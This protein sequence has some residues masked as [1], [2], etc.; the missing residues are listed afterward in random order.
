MKIL[1]GIVK[2]SALVF[3]G[4]IMLLTVGAYL[5]LP[6]PLKPLVVQSGSMEPAIRT[7]SLV[8]VTKIPANAIGVDYVENDIITFRSGQELVSHRIVNVFHRVD[9]KYFQVKGDANNT[10]DSGLVS[11]RD[12]VGKVNFTIPYVGRFVNF[13][14]QPLGFILLVTIP[15]LFVI[16]SEALVIVE[17]I[18]KKGSSKASKFDFIK[19][20]AMFFMTAVFLTGTHSFFSSVASSTNNT[21]TAA[22]FFV[23]RVVINE[24]NWAG[25]SAS[26]DDEWIELF[27]TT[28]QTIDISGWKLTKKSGTEVT[29][30]TIPTS[31]SIGPGGF[32]LISNFNIGNPLTVLNV[33][34][35]LVDTSVALSNATLQI[36]LYDN[37]SNVIDTAWD[38]SPPTKGSNTPPKASMER[39]STILD[40]SLHTSWHTA[41]TSENLILGATEHATPK[42]VNGP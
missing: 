33:T 16:I 22:N 31:Q 14:K 11:E 15:V 12:V 28:N 32:Y 42:A 8:F 23:P 41:T 27:N 21:F 34:P 20:L 40:G 5:N 3:F 9:G 38:G 18:R 6:L 26:T 2:Y 30:L 4:A 35:D 17:E 1:F 7:G 19:P 36:K 37:L 24:L 13:V 29:M 10:V 25:S 39:N